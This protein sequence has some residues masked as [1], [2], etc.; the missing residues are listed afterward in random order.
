MAVMLE[1][2]HTEFSLLETLVR[3]YD[4][5]RSHFIFEICEE[6]IKRFLNAQRIRFE[7]NAE[8]MPFVRY[9]SLLLDHM[10]NSSVLIGWTYFIRSETS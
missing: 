9:Q 2:S 4:H 8:R 1:M 5:A 6:A 10:Q 7:E 3:V